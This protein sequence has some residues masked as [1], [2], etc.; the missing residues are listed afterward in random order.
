[1][2]Q[3]YT[4][5]RTIGMLIAAIPFIF[6]ILSFKYVWETYYNILQEVQFVKYGT[7]LLVVLYAG[8]LFC[9]SL[10]YE[11]HRI[12]YH[13]SSM[14]ALSNMLIVVIGNL[15]GYLQ[16]A[17]VCGR[18]VTPRWMVVLTL[19]QIIIVVF[20]SLLSGWATRKLF[21]PKKMLMIYGVANSSKMFMKKLLERKDKYN[22]DKAISMEEGLENVLKEA[23]QYPC[24]ILSDIKSENRNKIL[25]LCYEKGIAVYLTPKISDILIRSG[26][27]IALFD[28][29]VVYCSEQPLDTTERIIKRT[30]DIIISLVILI[31]TS[32]ILLMTAIAIKVEDG[33]P[34]FFRQTRCTIHNRKF[35]VIKFRSMIVDAEKDG[36]PRPAVDGDPR[37]TKV[38]RFIRM[39]RIDEIPQI[40]NV[41]N[42]DMSVVGPR[43]ER[44]EHVEKYCEE[45]PEFVLRAKVKAGITGYAQISGKYNTSPYDKLK[46]DLMYILNYS[47]LQDI[48][49]LFLTLRVVFTK[50]STEGFANE[51]EFDNLIDRQ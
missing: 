10:I 5:R 50:S 40:F 29:P 27:N 38:G 33:G 6:E 32:P 16:I 15:V 48:R 11:G 42:N 8:I 31:L 25:K 35:N 26:E 12:G 18:L 39:T 47:L 17:L 36:K 46:M 43:P 9:L 4:I 41:L 2:K 37:I 1:M 51:K 7:L 45:V 19:V 30:M 28:V 44:V 3:H 23:E 14:I 34:I 13:K 22:I 20:W 24:V 49:L 21:P